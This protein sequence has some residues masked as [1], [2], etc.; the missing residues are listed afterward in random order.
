MACYSAHLFGGF[1]Q[2][3]SH[4]QPRGDGW[5]VECDSQ[6]A[7]AGDVEVDALSAVD[8][9]ASLKL[10]GFA[11]IL[12]EDEVVFG[13]ACEHAPLVVSYGYAPRLAGEEFEVD[14]RLGVGI[15][16][17]SGKVVAKGFG[18]RCVGIDDVAYD[19]E[20]VL[21]V[22]VALLAKNIFAHNFS[23]Y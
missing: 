13:V 11:L 6:H 17:R 22:V 21:W 14:A 7:V 19:V 10:Y 16:A 3:S 23:F 20:Y 15:D 1:E 9:C 8:S 5:S 4:E 2:E 18:Q 12:D